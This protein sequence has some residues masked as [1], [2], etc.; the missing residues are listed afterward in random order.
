M[1]A[2]TSGRHETVRYH[3]EFY[4]THDLFVEGSWLYRPSP[5]VLR[6]LDHIASSRPL[7]AVDLGCGVGRHTIPV[8][9]RLP[10]GSYVVGL[11]LLPV[12]AERLK[13]NVLA[14]GLE[15]AVQ[16]V[17]ADLDNVA[18]AP[19]SLDL[20]V[21][22]SALEHAADLSAL[23]RLLLH[24]QEATRP[25]GLHCLIIG[26]D[27]VEVDAAG[28]SRPARVEF[29]LGQSAAES[30][31][32]R[33]YENWEEIESSAAVFGVDEDRDGE[34]YTLSTTNLRRLFRRP[35]PD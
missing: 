26:T 4:A 3:E 27:K 31:L 24:L 21:S 35:P 34:R 16:A 12:A 20:L 18:L 7:V 19:Q 29:A 13:E 22:V 6:S 11:D 1:D 14:A 2:N 9:E 15:S 30:L 33:I 32:A 5:F 28:R 23:E 17:V 25:G 8:A 10:S